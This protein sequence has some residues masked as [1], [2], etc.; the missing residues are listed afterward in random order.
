MKKNVVLSFCTRQSLKID[1]AVSV[2][3]FTGP[4]AF[5]ECW[6]AIR[7]KLSVTQC[8][9]SFEMHFVANISTACRHGYYPGWPICHQAIR[10]VQN[11]FQPLICTHHCHLSSTLLSVVAVAMVN[12][13]AVTHFGVKKV[14]VLRTGR[15]A[16]AVFA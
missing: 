15:T 10:G 8:A 6:R 12:C 11:T 7:E 2:F 1:S 9:H 16:F 13:M 5:K 3:V 14:V 4:L